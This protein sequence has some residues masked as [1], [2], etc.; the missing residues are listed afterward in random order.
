MPTPRPLATPH[1]T[2]LDLIQ[3]LISPPF[4][5]HG[6]QKEP[7]LKGLA[8]PTE[9]QL[10]KEAQRKAKVIIASLW[11]LSY[12]LGVKYFEKHLNTNTLKT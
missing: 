2:R 10:F 1:I 5:N 3:Q 9:I 12:R 7:V 6:D 8:T 4:G 11:L